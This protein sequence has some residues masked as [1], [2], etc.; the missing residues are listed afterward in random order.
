MASSLSIAAAYDELARAE[1]ARI[2]AID[3]SQ[4]PHDVLRDALAALEDL[5]PPPA[6]D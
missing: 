3:A 2:R 4:P 1:P 6:A 5:L